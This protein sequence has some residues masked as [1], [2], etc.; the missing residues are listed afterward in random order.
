MGDERC[1]NPGHQEKRHHEGIAGHGDCSVFGQR[2]TLMLA[3]MRL[4]A[5][6]PSFF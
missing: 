2:S 5:L 3:V 4:D 6:R 1:N